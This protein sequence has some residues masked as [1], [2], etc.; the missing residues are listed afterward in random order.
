MS[1][2]EAWPLEAYHHALVGRPAP[3]RIVRD[4]GSWTTHDVSRWVADA[5]PVDRRLLDRVVEAPVLDLGCGPGRLTAALAARGVPALGVDLSAAAL[6]VAVKRGAPALRR[7]V[8]G[9][10]P[11]EGRWRTVLLADGNVGIGGDPGRLLGRIA[12]LVGDRG[13]VFVE[14]L[15]ADVDRRGLARLVDAEGRISPPFP[16][17]EVGAPALLALAGA[18]W[19]QALSWHDGGRAFVVLRRSQEATTHGSLTRTART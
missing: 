5:D 10:L 2:L 13:A 3:V 19:T 4:D 6:A 9:R 12:R 11:G 8:F 7:D 14:V 15:P 1:S 18:E 17:A 16:W